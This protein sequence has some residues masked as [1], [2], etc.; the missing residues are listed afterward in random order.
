[1]ENDDAVPPHLRR[2]DWCPLESQ[3]IRG[4]DDARSYYAH[5]LVAAGPHTVTFRGGSS[6]V[7]HFNPEET[8]CFSDALDANTTCPPSERVC[9]PG[10]SGEVR[11]FSLS[12]ARR[13]DEILPTLAKPAASMRAKL[14]PAAVQVFGQPDV[15]G[16][17][18]CVVVAPD[19]NVWFVRTSWL[20]SA[21]DYRNATN[22]PKQRAAWPPKT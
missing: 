1:M 17:R 10:A 22:P 6:V 18:T 19:R 12:R 8:H 14:S 7:V 15:R 4:L 21:M 5:R 11:R 3:W 2:F 16:E 13:M 9:R 20:S